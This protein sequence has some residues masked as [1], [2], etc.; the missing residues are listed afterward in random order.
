QPLDPRQGRTAAGPR[1]CGA[2]PRRILILQGHP[3]TTE[4]HLGHALAKAYAEGAREA[5]H[6]L[7]TID[8]AALEFPLLRSA[9]AWEHEPV[10]PSLAQAQADIA[11][12]EHLL[13]LYPL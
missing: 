7:R 9:Q 12:A 13:L 5:G 1:R 4:R 3:D 6:E 11:W 2:M 8:V 10:P